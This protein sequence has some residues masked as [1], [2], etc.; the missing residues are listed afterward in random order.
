MPEQQALGTL[1]L[2]RNIEPTVKVYC[3]GIAYNALYTDIVYWHCCSSC[4]ESYTGSTNVRQK[5]VFAM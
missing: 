2:N 5:N 4:G 1:S 3:S